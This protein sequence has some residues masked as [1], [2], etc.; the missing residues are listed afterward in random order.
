MIENN[1]EPKDTKSNYREMVNQM[2]KKEFTLVKMQEYGFWPK[3]LPTPY[4]IQ[5][6][7]TPD[8]YAKRQGLLKEYQ[9]L[10]DQIAKLYEEKDDINKKLRELRKEYNETW[11]LEK[12]RLDISQ[13]IMRESIER[14]AERKAQRELEKQ[15]RSLKWQQKKSDQIVFIGRGY[16]SSLKDT[17]IDEDKLKLQE[18][19]II[20]TDRNL[21]EVLGIDYPT[22]RFLV[23]HRDVVLIDH[24]HHYKIPKKKGGERSIA[25]PKSKLKAAQRAILEKIL[26]KIRIS[27]QAHGFLKGKSVVTGAEV[28]LKQP[29][30]LINMDLEDFFPT[31][32]FERVLGMFKAFGYSG[33]ISSLFAM[34]C[35][36]C[37]RMEIEVKGR[38]KYVATSGRIL[39]QGSPA[40]PMITNIICRD[41]D[42]RLNGLAKCFGF[43]YTRYADDMSFSINEA[44]DL[45]EGRF[46]GLVSKIVSE[47][48]FKINK[49]KTRY[50]RKNNCQSITG[51]VVN[52]DQLAVRK[53]WVK[54]FRAAIYNAT[55]QKKAGNLSGSTKNEISGMASW[56]KSVNSEKYK[57]M[58]DEALELIKEK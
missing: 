48:G 22:L 6:N 58:I 12:I 39:P 35:T 27:D 43:V 5:Q 34:I 50:L 21:A 17:Q 44:S 11:D 8:S 51:I 13:K 40:S 16:S 41:L 42:V 29:E 20:M 49:E 3:D 19:P 18:L 15:K 53:K 7:E 38:T 31:I 4:E 10:I 1:T 33:Y 52:N 45:K 32:T 23:Y 56:L 55:K 37:E 28:H 14:R 57:T 46:C 30:M 25:A 47:E 24:Y 54:K 9:K 36:Y 2:G 26:S